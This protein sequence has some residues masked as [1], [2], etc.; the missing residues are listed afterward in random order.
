M[1]NRANAKVGL[2]VRDVEATIGMEV[3]F[4]I[5]STRIIPVST[6][7][8]TPAILKDTGNV[9]K[10]YEEIAA[11]FAPPQDRANRTLL[12]AIRKDR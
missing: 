3:S 9:A 7:E 1:L 6:N 4:E 5:P 11:Y 8:G 12:R 10:R 2:S